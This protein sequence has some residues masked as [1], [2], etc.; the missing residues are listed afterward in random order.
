MAVVCQS[1][2]SGRPANFVLL[3]R[4]RPRPIFF[5][6]YI[7][8]APKKILVEHRHRRLGAQPK[9]TFNK[10]KTNDKRGNQIRRR[11]PVRVVYPAG[12]QGIK[13]NA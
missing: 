11:R 8:Y 9:I 1:D 2:G 6:Q 10:N 13:R 3:D 12:I 5:Y 4:P 7:S